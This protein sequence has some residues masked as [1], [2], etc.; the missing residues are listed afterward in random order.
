M[1]VDRSYAVQPTGRRIR[2]RILTRVWK[3]A[4]A[5][6]STLSSENFHGKR[7][8]IPSDSCFC[9]KNKLLS[10]LFPGF[11]EVIAVEGAMRH[12]SICMD[13]EGTIIVKIISHRTFLAQV[14][15]LSHFGRYDGCVGS[16][17][18]SDR[19]VPAAAAEP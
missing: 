14:E 3:Y 1:C 6:G 9:S 13:K 10:H 17:G 15:I 16:P 7:A 19:P 4:W 5:V 2:Y 8:F 18:R 12:T 11:A